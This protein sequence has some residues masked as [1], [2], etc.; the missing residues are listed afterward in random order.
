MQ[1]PFTEKQLLDS[2]SY[3]IF[4]QEQ[5]LLAVELSDESPQRRLMGTLSG[6]T[7]LAPKDSENLLREDLKKTFLLYLLSN[8]P[9]LDNKKTEADVMAAEDALKKEVGDKI[10]AEI[11]KRTYD[12]VYKCLAEALEISKVISK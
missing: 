8:D 5:F 9:Q 1:N 6:K 4:D 2:P 12:F 10:G 7:E 3:P 11:A